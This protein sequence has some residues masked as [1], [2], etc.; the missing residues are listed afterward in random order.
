MSIGATF[1]KIHK[2]LHSPEQKHTLELD[3]VWHKI[4]VHPNGCRY[5]DYNGIRVMQQNTN[6]P[7]EYAARARN[8]ECLSWIMW[9]KDRPWELIDTP[10]DKI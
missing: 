2:A 5:I 1:L 7:S 6:K 3:G 9:T 8:G 4:N 10:L